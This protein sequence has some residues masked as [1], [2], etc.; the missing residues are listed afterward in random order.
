MQAIYSMH[1]IQVQNREALTV[2]SKKHS[3]LLQKIK[4]K[5]KK[6]MRRM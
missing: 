1:G 6:K 2:T 5:N 3:L 4:I